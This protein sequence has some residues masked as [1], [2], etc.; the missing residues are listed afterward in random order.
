M[1]VDS[2]AELSKMGK[3][4]STF[5]YPAILKGKKRLYIFET[6]GILRTWFVGCLKSSFYTAVLSAR[7]L[8][9]IWEGKSD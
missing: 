3:G 5:N 4:Q 9:N 8:Y 2:L 1:K 6:G 7:L